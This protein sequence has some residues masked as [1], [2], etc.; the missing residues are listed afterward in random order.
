MTREE[1]EKQILE[2]LDKY[3]LMRLPYCT[4]VA[5]KITSLIEQ[6]PDCYDKRFVEW[7]YPL[8]SKYWGSDK[9]NNGMW[10]IRNTIVSRRVYFTL[11]ELY[12]YWQTNIKDK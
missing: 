1:L 12:L 2:I 5:E 7:M 10:Y 4:V 9:P 8:Y 6:K 3:C 11:D